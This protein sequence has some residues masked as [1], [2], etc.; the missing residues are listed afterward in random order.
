MKTQFTFLL[1]FFVSLSLVSLQAQ[2]DECAH[3]RTGKFD[4]F[5]EG[6]FSTHLVRTKKYQKEYSPKTGAKIKLRIIWED[7]CTYRLYFVKANKA[8]L[9]G[10]TAE[11]MPAYLNCRIISVNGDEYQHVSTFKGRD[12]VEL[13]A[14]IIKTGD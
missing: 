7:D 11:D 6:K 2:T 8:F 1:L 3:F 4:S 10:R 13:R 9:K 14:T 5:I 12:D